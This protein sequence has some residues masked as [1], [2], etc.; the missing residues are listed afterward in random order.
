MSYEVNLSV[1]LA[2]G[3]VAA[4]FVNAVIFSDGTTQGDP[5]GV[6]RLFA[7]RTQN[8]TYY[9]T[10]LEDL[11]EASETIDETRQF[12]ENSY[13]STWSVQLAK[14]THERTRVYEQL[15]Q[16]QPQERKPYIVKKTGE[17][18]EIIKLYSANEGVISL[19]NEAK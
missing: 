10:Q 12:K 19:E 4:L 9:K 13:S 15:S 14:P 2:E 16:L 5:A 1:P 8:A 3:V 17:I 6:K 18:K 11:K 7:A